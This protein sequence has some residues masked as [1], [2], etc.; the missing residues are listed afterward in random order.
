MRDVG[1]TLTYLESFRMP[2]ALVRA[3]VVLEAIS[4]ARHGVRYEVLL[5]GSEREALIEAVMADHRVLMEVLSKIN[6][7]NLQA[8]L[9]E[10]P[11]THMA[12]LGGKVKRPKNMMMKVKEFLVAHK[13]RFKSEGDLVSNA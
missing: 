9:A 5:A 13:D 1:Y 8:Y 3:W 4:T 12:A 6:V 11:E 7:R 2:Q 10:H